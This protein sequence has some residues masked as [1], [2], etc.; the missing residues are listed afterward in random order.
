M[1]LKLI[2]SQIIYDV[3]K[4]KFRLK[5]N[6]FLTLSVLIGIIQHESKLAMEENR[7]TYL[8]HNNESS[9]KFKKESQKS[10]K[11]SQMRITF[12]RTEEYI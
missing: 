2:A 4:S 5:Y 1:R 9:S 11:S 3:K 6:Q 12:H 7:D 8:K 10:R